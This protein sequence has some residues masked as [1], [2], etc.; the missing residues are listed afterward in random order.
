ML[1][2]LKMKTTMQIKEFDEFNQAL[3]ELSIQILKTEKTSAEL[4]RALLK[5][6][7]F[8]KN[9]QSDS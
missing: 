7:E 2:S 4:I 3:K 9:G 6:H 1:T 8:N 5:L